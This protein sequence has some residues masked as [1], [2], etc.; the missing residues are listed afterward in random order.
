MRD[1]LGL[2]TVVALGLGTL[3]LPAWAEGDGP[4]QEQSDREGR[5]L[6]GRL[7]EAR[8]NVELLSLELETEKEQLRQQLPSLKQFE[9]GFPGMGGMGGGFGGM[10]GMGDSPPNPED[11]KKKRDT[12]IA[13]LRKHY[14][15]LK[16]ATLETA[17]QLA[18]E[19]RRLAELEGPPDG[20]RKASDRPARSAT[21]P[22]GRSNFT[23][24]KAGKYLINQRRI[25]FVEQSEN[26][27]V[28]I[29]FGSKQPVILTGEAAKEFLQRM[30]SES[31]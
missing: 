6:D 5:G 4:K 26:G 7:E 15:E 19:R 13:S 14:E 16:A 25:E 21:E 9:F 22:V 18:Q 10:G 8:L 29:N 30:A 2:A 23:F 20:G 24:I 3:S 1:A 27:W 12:L 11:V 17:K 31:P 28:R